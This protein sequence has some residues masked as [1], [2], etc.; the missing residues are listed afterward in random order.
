MMRDESDKLFAHASYP[1][2]LFT[3]ESG[4]DKDGIAWI[5]SCCCR[6]REPFPVLVGDLVPMPVKLDSVDGVLDV[7]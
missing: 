4:G 6:S 5:M 2:E 3:L 1:G 7:G